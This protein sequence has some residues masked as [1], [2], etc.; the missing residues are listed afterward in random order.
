[1]SKEKTASVKTTDAFLNRTILPNG[2][3][4]LT[5][6]MPQIRS[7]SLGFW[8]GVGSRDEPLEISGI[9]HFLEHLLFKGTARRSAR[10]IAEAFDSLGGELNAFS[11]KEYT[12]YYA[13]VLDDYLEPAI[14]IMSDMIRNSLFRPAD[15]DAERKVILEEISMH[16][17]SPDD[18]I[19]DLFASTLWEAHPLGQGVLGHANIIKALNQEDLTGYFRRNYSPSNMVLAVAGSVDHDKLVDLVIKHFGQEEWGGKQE[20]HQVLP[21]VHSQTAVYKRTTEQAH[22]VLGTLGLPRRHPDRFALAVLDNILGGGMSSRLFQKIREEKALAYSVFSYHSMFIE[23]GLMAVYAGTNP[24]NVDNVISLI[25]QEIKQLLSS[26]ITAEE[27]ARSKGH[28]K[29]NLVLGLEDSGGRMTRIGKSELVQGEILSLDELIERIDAVSRAKVK[30]LAE[31][32]FGKNPLVLTVIGPFDK[33][34]FQI[35]MF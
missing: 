17:D 20:R 11:A 28:I 18:L 29:G 15:I 4:I 35:P 5:E 31:E 25:G 8:V 16:E 32:I 27:L 10:E 9:S 19:H 30:E 14:E 24:E 7:A 23:T 2:L 12:C 22:V 1:M 26:G 13:K 21:E 3:R 33:E 34:S 6:R